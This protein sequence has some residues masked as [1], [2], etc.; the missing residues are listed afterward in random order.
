[1]PLQAKELLTTEIE[2]FQLVRDTLKAW[3][4][5]GDK[6]EDEWQKQLLAILPLIFPKYIAVI[7]KLSIED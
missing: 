6:S 5:A 2:K 3:L 7:E 4:K 1:V